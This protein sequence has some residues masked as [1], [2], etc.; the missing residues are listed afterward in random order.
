MLDKFV[1]PG[2]LLAKCAI[3]DFDV[4]LLGCLLVLEYCSPGFRV[5]FS[6]SGF[7][8]LCRLA[9]EPLP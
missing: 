9:M 6:A 3:C 7:L 1:I 4:D 5:A 8:I 2:V